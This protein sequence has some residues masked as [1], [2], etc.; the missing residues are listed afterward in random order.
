MLAYCDSLLPT[1]WGK[2]TQN[3]GKGERPSAW[4]D[5]PANNTN[6]NDKL[7]SNTPLPSRAGLK[8]DQM[9]PMPL[10]QN[11]NN[12]QNKC[13]LLEFCRTLITNYY[14]KE[15]LARLFLDT[16][17]YSSLSITMYH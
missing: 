11:A 6:N 17:H 1:L 15:W 7:V 13:V 5:M 4:A 10:P 8:H 3:G 2:V 14:V 16:N 12:L 9:R